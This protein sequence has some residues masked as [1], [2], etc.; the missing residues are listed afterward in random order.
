MPSLEAVSL[1]NKK[2]GMFA[3][4]VAVLICHVTDFIESSSLAYRCNR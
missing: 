2:M 4:R 3:F 1:I